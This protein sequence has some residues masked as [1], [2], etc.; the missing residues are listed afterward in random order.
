MNVYAQGDLSHP[1]QPHSLKAASERHEPIH[2]TRTLRTYTHAR[3]A[4][5]TGRGRRDAGKRK[6]KG[7][8]YVHQLHTSQSQSQRE[9]ERERESSQGRYARGRRRRESLHGGYTFRER[10]PP[11][12]IYRRRDQARAMQFSEPT[13]HRR[14]IF[15]YQPSVCSICYKDCARRVRRRERRYTLCA[16]Q[17]VEIV[18]ERVEFLSGWRISVFCAT[19]FI[20]RIIELL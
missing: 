15:A 19:F 17:L 5:E 3:Q 18:V 4:K 12:N 16:V 10:R 11:H 9:R 8:V 14:V 13:R 1:I 6:G 2:T 20:L 7:R